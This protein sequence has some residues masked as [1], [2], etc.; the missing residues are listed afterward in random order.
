MN[1]S[2]RLSEGSVNLRS[3]PVGAEVSTW[4]NGLLRASP[5]SEGLGCQPLRHMLGIAT[6]NG[7]QTGGLGPWGQQVRLS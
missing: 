3:E 5:R 1:T 2:R 6:S 4:Q 7:R